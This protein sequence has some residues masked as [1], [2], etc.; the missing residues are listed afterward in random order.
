MGCIKLTKVRNN[1][2][3]LVSP[4]SRNNM[5]PEE[6]IEKLLTEIRDGQRAHLE[7]YRRVT[8]ESLRVQ[9]ESYESQ[10]G[11]IRMYRRLALIGMIIIA[12]LFVYILWLAQSLV[13]Y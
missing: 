2:Q 9:R 7:E 8:G 1:D 3:S 11:H 12:A 6:R 5:T 4:T 13:S 10:T